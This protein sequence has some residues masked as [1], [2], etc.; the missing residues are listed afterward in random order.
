MTEV[1]KYFIHFQ[2]GAHRLEAAMTGVPDRVPVFAQMHEFVMRQMGLNAREFFTKSELLVPATLEIQKK[3][4]ID[5]PYICYDIYNIEAEALGQKVIFSDDHMPEIDRGY[6]LVRD[7]EDLKKIKTPNFESDARFPTIIE[8]FVLFR[9]MTG[10]EPELQFTAPFSLAA[11]IRGI[12]QLILDICLD[13]EFARHLLEKLTDDIIAP[14]IQ[15]QKAQFPYALGICGSDSTASFP[16]VNANILE[17]W[18]SPYILRLREMCGPRVYVANWTGERYLK[19][20]I[21]MLNKKLKVCLTF[22]EGQDPDVAELGPE[23]Y[24]SFAEQHGVPLI[25]GIGADFMALSSPREVMQ[26]VRQYID[27]GGKNGHFVL[28]FCNLGATTPPENV[29]AAIKAVNLYGVYPL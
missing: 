18:V 14:W 23:I 25:L 4:G 13:P 20:P 17:N 28:Y 15:Y 10:I 11:N 26:R 6:P 9:K 24:K 21:E 8:M 12:E 27:V 3:Y 22:I 1:Q 5:I 16:I 2:E 29:T 7:R 19:N